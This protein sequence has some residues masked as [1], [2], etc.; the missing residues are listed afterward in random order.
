MEAAARLAGAALD[1]VDLRAHAATHPR[2]GTVDHILYSPLGSTDVQ[3]AVQAAHAVA[4]RL[5]EGPPAVPVY[6]CA[7][8]ALNLK[9]YAPKIP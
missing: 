9:P 7:P 4:G 1:L 8:A 5:A 6:L 3:A 2:L